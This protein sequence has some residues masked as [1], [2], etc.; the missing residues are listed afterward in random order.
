[1]V[2]RVFSISPKPQ[3]DSNIL[4][5]ASWQTGVFRQSIFHGNLVQSVEFLRK[6]N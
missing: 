3:P 1:M 2:L 5:K 6:Y 4:Q